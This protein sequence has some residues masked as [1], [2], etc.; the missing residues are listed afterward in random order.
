MV[1]L[2]SD[3]PDGIA[4]GKI[5]NNYFLHRDCTIGFE[6]CNIE[7]VMIFFIADERCEDLEK[8][9]EDTMSDFGN[10]FDDFDHFDEDGFDDE[11]FIDD[12]FYEDAA[13]CEDMEAENMDIQDNSEYEMID[14]E[15]PHKDGFT[16][17]D[18]FYLGASMGL[19]YEE[20]QKEVKRKKLLKKIKKDNK[21]KP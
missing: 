7:T 16:G 20:G 1:L 18:A 11:R 9:G 10:N 2:I 19:V 14:N 13:F 3:N 6:L 17:Q 4:I 5:L 8:D 12:E 15:K 21:S